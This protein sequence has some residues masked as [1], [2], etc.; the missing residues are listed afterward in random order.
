MIPILA[1]IIAGQ[2][3]NIT[4][5][6]GFFFLILSYVLG[7]SFSYS[8]AGVFSFWYLWCATE[9]FRL[10]FKRPHIDG[11]VWWFVL[12][13]CRC[14]VSMNYSYLCSSRQGLIG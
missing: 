2:A 11:L 6:K 10:C 14:L 4:D 8:M 13:S 12:L 9:R 7:M 3:G 1:G 5:K